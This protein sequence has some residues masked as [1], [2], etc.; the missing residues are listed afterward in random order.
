VPGARTGVARHPFELQK[1]M[2]VE[3]K[4]V[5]LDCGFRLDL[6]VDGAV[7]VES[8]SV[9]KL[10]PAHKAQVLTYLK[11]TGCRLGMLL[12]FNEERMADGIQRLVLG[13]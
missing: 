9:E 6:L 8:K 5:K 3:Y 1:A 13:L 4:G 10:S 12:N 7:V 11:L 2:P